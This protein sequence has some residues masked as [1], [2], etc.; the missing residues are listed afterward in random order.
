L[1]LPDSTFTSDDTH[2]VR[3]SL[4]HVLHATGGLI[5]V[6]HLTRRHH[7][8]VVNN[9][10]AAREVFSAV[11]RITVV[12][13]SIASAVVNFTAVAGITAAVVNATAVAG[14]TAAVVN[15]TAVARVAAAVVN[16][17]AV[18]GITAAVVNATAVARVAAAVVNASAVAGM[19]SAAAA[20]TYVTST[21]A[22]CVTAATSAATMTCFNG[23]V[24]RGCRSVRRRLSLS[25][26]KCEACA[27][28]S[29]ARVFQNLH[30]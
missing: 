16:A 15:A 8:A 23:S 7:V 12:C 19:E 22:T 28:H 27:D 1:I 17:S 4:H 2:D 10:V 6:T 5:D 13:T 9:R 14:I 24:G 11:S 26:S 18:A 29:D 3:I 21:S 30:E 20:T 25:H